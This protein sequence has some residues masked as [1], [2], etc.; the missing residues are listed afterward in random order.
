MI[1]IT[2]RQI[3]REKGVKDHRQHCPSELVR[4]GIGPQPDSLEFLLHCTLGTLAVLFFKFLD[5][6]GS[7]PPSIIELVR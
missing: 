1:H 5:I 3:T 6:Y 4:V 7:V 2:K